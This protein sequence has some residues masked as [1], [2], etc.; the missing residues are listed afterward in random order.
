M[1]TLLGV[2]HGEWEAELVDHVEFFKSLG[3]VVPKE[4]FDEHDKV[5]ERFKR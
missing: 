2:D 3:G 1:A 4:L 5:V